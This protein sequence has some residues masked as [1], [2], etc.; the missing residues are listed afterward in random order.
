MVLH[1]Y[2]Y[3]KGIYVRDIYELENIVIELNSAFTE[4]LKETK[5]QVILEVLI[6]LQRR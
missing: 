2:A 1:C 3:W 4:T 5:V 6:R